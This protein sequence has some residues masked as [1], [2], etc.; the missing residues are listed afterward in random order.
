MDVEVLDELPMVL[1]CGT[2][3]GL[4][5]IDYSN[6]VVLGN[7]SKDKNIGCLAEFLQMQTQQHLTQPITP[8]E[9]KA[10]HSKQI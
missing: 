1:L 4:L 3:C 8:K 9:E 7:S 10:A 5:G 2:V 6:D